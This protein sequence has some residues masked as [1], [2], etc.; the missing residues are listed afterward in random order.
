MT[1]GTQVV[2]TGV[3][4]SRSGSCSVAD[5]GIIGAKLPGSVTVILVEKLYV[6]ELNMLSGKYSVAVVEAWRR[7]EP[8]Y[9]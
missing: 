8:C 7:Y 4:G 2:T 5:F 1:V 9:V 6:L 3:E